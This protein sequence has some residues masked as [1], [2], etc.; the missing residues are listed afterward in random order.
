MTDFTSAYE[1]FVEAVTGTEPDNLLN[2]RTLTR[3]E[4]TLLEQGG[5]SC[6]DWSSV[7]ISPS[8]RL[9]LIRNCV[10][11]GRVLIHLPE[12]RLQSTCFKNCSVSG[13]VFI[14]STGLISGMILYPGC[15]VGFC[16]RVEWTSSPSFLESAIQGG[17]ETGERSLPLLPTLSHA[18]AAWLASADGRTEA[19]RLAALLSGLKADIKGFIG[20]GA[21]LDSCP[22]VENSLILDGAKITSAS[23]VRGS[24]L[25]PGSMVSDGA[26]VRSSVLQ[27]NARA[28]S[29]AL[30]EDSIVG[31]CSIVE[32]HGKL[33]CS[34]LGADSTL[35][36]GEITAS[37]VGPLTGMHHQSLLIAALWPG[38]RGNIGYGANIGSN[39]TSRLPDQEIRPGTG[40]F[41]GLS[42]SVKFPSDFS[43]S[44]FSVIATGLTTLPQRVEFPFSLICLP[45]ERPEGIPEGW[46]RLVPG[47]MLHSNL[48]AI[49][50]GLWKFG[51]RRKSVHTQVETGVFTHEILSMVTDSLINLESS[52]GNTVK[53]AGKNFIT[54]EDRL[55]GIEVYRKY[56]RYFTL[57]D[58]LNA[59]S[60]ST[61]EAGELMDLVR[62]V[63]RAVG[64]SKAKD[65]S[66]GSKI[67]NDYIAIHPS[68]EEDPFMV[69]FEEK[70][71]EMER[72]L[73]RVRG[74]PSI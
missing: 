44:P 10:F 74:A 69:D 13:P 9:D 73:G 62:Q 17:L 52:S 8:T 4:I 48:Y 28:D 71:T 65:L 72:E 11:Q 12:G 61:G 59:G 15:R 1:E 53:G 40:F 26:L 22:L 66:R 35:G 47:W 38:G 21:V 43:R 60:L 31:E 20:E 45:A 67:I 23:A 6:C 27:W 54:K 18:Q 39:H 63:R 32:K 49:L 16:G 24:I 19:A 25:F 68:P 29:M 3:E 41:F 70:A 57:A 46:M 37:V 7:L 58:K 51:K 56:L 34:F 33:G 64:E 55:A 2:C 50:R 5:S 36:E 42:T 14:D 30:V